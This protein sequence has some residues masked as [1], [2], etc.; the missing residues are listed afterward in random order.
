MRQPKIRSR[1]NERENFDFRNTPKKFESVTEGN[2]RELK[3]HCFNYANNTLKGNFAPGALKATL[4]SIVGSFNFAL[5][6]L[7]GDYSARKNNLETARVSGLADVQAQ[8][9]DF[10]KLAQE[11]D[12]AFDV[13]AEAYSRIYGQMPS[14]NLK[15]G[16]SKID[17]IKKAYE[18]LEK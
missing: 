16:Q 11:H 4:E 10:E 7:E 14:G 6:R 8:I 2:I 9:F 12:E 17:N 15:V 5:A 13:Y 1:F 18:A 3:V